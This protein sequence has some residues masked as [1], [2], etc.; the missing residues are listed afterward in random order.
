MT[1]RRIAIVGS[2]QAGL[3]A[4]HALVQAGHEVTL[5]S[6]RSADQWLHDARP[7]G[8]AARFELAL[9]YERELGLA[10]WEDVAP[11]GRGVH[12]TFCPRPSN[13]LVTM[14]G[15]LESTYF[16]AVDLRLQSHRWMNDLEAA[17]GRVVI[18]Q[19]DPVRLDAIAA[20]HELV[21][22]ATGRGPLAELFP[23]N[24]ERS[25]YV[26][27]QRKLAMM[28][29]TGA[30]QSVPGVPF[31]PVKFNFFAPF[32]EVF[33]APYY[34]RD[35]G[36]TWCVLFEAREG[37]PLDRFDGCTTGH[38]VVARAKAAINELM[39]WDAAWAANLELADPN[40]WLIGAVTPTVRE[41]VGRLPS[42]RV[43]M[44]IGDTAVAL[45]P[46]AGQGANHGNKLVRHVA[47]AIAAAP[48]ATFDAD[49]MTRTFEAF[50]DDHGA[51]TVTFNNMFLEPLTAAGKLLL[52]S[53]M[54]SN[55][56]ADSSAQRIADAV[57]ENFVDPR[58]MTRA[59]VD[60]LAARALV[61]ERTGHS[62]RRQFLGGASRVGFGQLR[63]VF[64]AGP[65]HVDAHRRTALR[66]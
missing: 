50:W 63:R 47:E 35:H 10:H 16:Q 25:V 14:T 36:A 33:W 2:G 40:G 21:L 32:G 30:A 9:A 12:L 42:G 38:E 54:G 15:R 53:Q 57:V 22:V 43:V 56:L 44:P 7:T 65:A 8:T 28:I 19:V 58:R 62:W 41:P 55:G 24:A 61:A 46:I 6:D 31:L 45:D 11:K 13:R 37:G 26:R 23:R 66:L 64:G 4:A 29:V 3:L 5:Y 60:P 48:D 18:E 17:G 49:W 34:H 51:A 1:T 27:P 20:Q 52:I 39:P 59:F